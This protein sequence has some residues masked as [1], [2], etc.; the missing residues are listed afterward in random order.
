MKRHCAVRRIAKHRA[1]PRDSVDALRRC[2]DDSDLPVDND[3]VENQIRP[4]AFGLGPPF[5]L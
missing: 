3:W 4:I 1:G 2:V 5:E